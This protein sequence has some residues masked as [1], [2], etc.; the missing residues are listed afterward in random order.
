[1]STAAPIS[2]LLP[3]ELVARLDAEARRQTRSRNNLARVL[4]TEALDRLDAE[5]SGLAI[6]GQ[7]G[8]TGCPAEPTTR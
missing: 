8:D 7:I 3:P 1:M 6:S 5:R 4:L 2:F